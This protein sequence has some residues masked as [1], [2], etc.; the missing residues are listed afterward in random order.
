[1]PYLLSLKF[2]IDTQNNPATAA[3]F[4][5]YQSHVP[6]PVAR[7]RLL[8][9][10]TPV[11]AGTLSQGSAIIIADP[12]QIGGPC[13][14]IREENGQYSVFSRIAGFPAFTGERLCVSPD[15]RIA[16]DVNFHTGNI[17]CDGDLLVEGSILAGFK[18]SAKQ[19]TVNGTIENAEISCSGNLVCKG[20]IVGCQDRALKCGGSLW[21]KYV[22]NSSLEVKQN[23]FISGSCLHSRMLAGGNIVLCRDGSVLVGGRSEAGQAIFASIYGARRATPT[24]LKTG[25]DP[26]LARDAVVLRDRQE[27]LEKQL[28]ELNE[29]RLEIETFFSLNP[30]AEIPAG[31]REE[32]EI[33]NGRIAHKS[34][35]L[36]E[37]QAR[38]QRLQQT[39]AAFRQRYP[40]PRIV[41]CEH[42]FSG[43]HLEI[44]AVATRLEDEG[45]AAVYGENNGAIL[46]LAV[47]APEP[48]TI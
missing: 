10:M 42:I 21:C 27:E 46:N 47:G 34:A 8:A 17:D 5:H 20:G 11:A 28:S 9:I 41:V 32:Q 4:D 15:L 39:A 26:F 7:G 16:G 19:L 18:V 22:E 12:E 40:E 37:M 36:A 38:R 23:I 24:E 29:R 2:G 6:E 44:G 31:L 33:V 45:P 1:M 43:V 30:A 13:V 25:N 3:H 48:G 35:R 14:E